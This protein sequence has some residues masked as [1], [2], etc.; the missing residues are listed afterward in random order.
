MKTTVFVFF[1]WLFYFPEGKINTEGA[2]TLAGLFGIHEADG[3]HCGHN[4]DVNSVMNAEAIKWYIQKLNKFGGLPFQIGFEAYETC[5]LDKEASLQAV[6]MLNKALD[7]N[8]VIGVVGPESN[9]EAEAVSR[10]LGAVPQNSQLVQ[11]SFSATAP[12]LG[13][14]EEFPN[15]VRVVPNDDVKNEMIVLY[16]KELKWNRI[17]IVYEDNVYGRTEYA[18]VKSRAEEESIC[19]ALA[20][21]INTTVGIKASEISQMLVDIIVGNSQSRPAINGIVLI[22]SAPVAKV[23]MS[24]L[25]KSEYSST[26]IIM[27]SGANNLDEHVYRRYDGK[28][29][30]KS[31]GTLVVAP[32]YRDVVEFTQH[33]TSIFTNATTFSIESSTNTWLLDVFNKVTE[34]ATKTCSFNPLTDA[35]IETAFRQQP[36]SVSYAITAAHALVK[37]VR[38]LRTEFCSKNVKACGD[39]LQNFKTGN[40]IAALKGLNVQFSTD[41]RWRPDSLWNDI[42]AIDHSGEVSLQED[43][44]SYDLFNVQ[45]DLSDD[46]KFEKIN[47][48]TVIDYN[49]IRDYDASGQEIL[50]P[51][52]RIAQCRSG[53]RC[54]ECIPLPQLQEDVLYESGDIYVIGV[55]PVFEKSGTQ[56]CGAISDNNG[57]QLAESVRFAVQKVNEKTGDN[58]HFFPGIKIGVIIINSCSSPAVAQRKVYDLHKNGLTLDNGTVVDV[59]DKIIGYV[60][61]YTSTVSMAVAEV[62]SILQ[63]VQISFA[64]TSPALSDRTNFPYFMRVVTP[65]DAQARAM[66]EIVKKLNA[67]YI[68]I[69]YSAGDYGKDGRDKVKDVA[70]ANG[71]CVVQDISVNEDDVSVQIYDKLI[72]SAEARVVI[73]F[74]Y[75]NTL[76]KVVSALTKKMKKGEFLFIGSETWARDTT[77]IEEDEN[78][79][80]LGSLTVSLEMYQ[81]KEL[82]NHIQKIKSKPFRDDP[83]VQMFLQAKRKCYFDLSFDKTQAEKCSSS[84]DHSIDPDFTLDTYD[85]QAYVATKSLL[86]GA[87]SYFKENCGTAS[88]SLC[89]QFTSNAKGLVDEILKTKMDLDGSGSKMKVFD[90][91]GDGNIGYRIYNIQK[92]E[93]D[94]SKLVYR[95]IGRFPLEGTFTFETDILLY[96]TDSPIN[97][98]CPNTRVCTSCLQEDGDNGVESTDESKGKE[99]SNMTLV[100]GLAVP[101]GL[102]VVVIVILVV[103]LWRNRRKHHDGTNDFYLRPRVQFSQNEM[104]M[105][106]EDATPSKIYFEIPTPHDQR[107]YVPIDEKVRQTEDF[108]DYPKY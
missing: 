48:K 79:V 42:S 87:N 5:W 44:P 43:V 59:K 65:D 102:A 8:T 89:K 37:A 78:H 53:K 73:A 16:M 101:F 52:V 57:Y 103:L 67:D 74:L 95:E 34:C 99:E 98:R 41:F 14:D 15:F 56:D 108:D 28:V 93:V 55:I 40:M 80:M 64:S 35:E 100:I 63:I 88:K 105:Q 72:Q 85:T 70:R 58:S 75:P 23:L 66:I 51:N 30:S 26:P 17:A 31:K 38:S 84:N 107:R 69:V 6:Q 3:G 61:E 39:F 50:W 24:A 77:I 22:A 62:L 82:R 2:V 45:S 76:K 94:R 25:D 9:S 10:I 90:S 4:V 106:R 92:D 20:R 86:A 32:T 7:N 29:F 12:D 96:P 19:I 60:A 68:Q 83:W 49:K 33:W 91:N 11:V 104:S 46:L 27:L 71:I 81:D 18:S 97:S 36:V 13:N 21:G 1:N 47:K 54:S